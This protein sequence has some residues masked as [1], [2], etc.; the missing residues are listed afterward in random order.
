M[1][2]NT[3]KKSDKISYEVMK[4]FGKLGDRGK[5]ELRFRLVAWNGS[6]PKYDIRPWGVNANGEEV[7]GKGITLTGSEMEALVAICNSDEEE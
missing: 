6:D 4:D 7:C 5:Y 1:K 2:F 3:G